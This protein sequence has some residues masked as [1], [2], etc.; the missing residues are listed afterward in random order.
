MRS[1]YTDNL[2]FVDAVTRFFSE[3]TGRCLVVSSRDTELLMRWEKSGSSVATICEGIEEA[4]GGLKRP[5]RD[6]F[7]CKAFVEPKL[8]MPTSAMARTRTAT[9]ATSATT[10]SRRS[11]E[12]ISIER[13]ADA[14]NS[15]TSPTVKSAYEAAL[16][17]APQSWDDL[18]N[19]QRVMVDTAL[20][21]MATEERDRVEQTVH[22]RYGAQLA[23]MS[24]TSADRTFRAKRDQVV[25]E[26]FGLVSLI[27]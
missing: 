13:L 16:S 12:E 11:A 27:D 7:A 3:K 21:V 25:C 17:L 9:N 24:E 6:L 23:K 5:P 20:S 4:I 18:E 2:S 10:L 15:A 8:T 26:M 19:A 22:D 14:A 1:R